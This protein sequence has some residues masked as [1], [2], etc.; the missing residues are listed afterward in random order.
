MSAHLMTEHRQP[1]CQCSMNQPRLLVLDGGRV[2]EVLVPV[3]QSLPPCPAPALVRFLTKACGQVLLTREQALDFLNAHRLPV[4]LLRQMVSCGLGL[5]PLRELA[6]HTRNLP[7]QRCHH[8]GR[9]FNRRVG[10]ARNVE[11]FRLWGQSYQAVQVLACSIAC[12]VNCVHE[13]LEYLKCLKNALG[14][15]RALKRQVKAIK[16]FTRLLRQEEQ[17]SPPGG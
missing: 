13:N 11:L 10:P 7:R 16:D 8:C 5:Y 6:R 9:R 2:V 3:C 4:R 15:T 14:L 12:Y 1:H 17:N